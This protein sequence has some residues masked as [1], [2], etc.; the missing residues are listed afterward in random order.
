MRRSYVSPTEHWIACT[1]R[2]VVHARS[3]R[4]VKHQLQVKTLKALAGAGIAIP[5][6]AL[7][8]VRY[9]AERTWKEEA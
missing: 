1:L 2:Y 3:R 8:L 9:P 4:I 6:P 5:S 7:T